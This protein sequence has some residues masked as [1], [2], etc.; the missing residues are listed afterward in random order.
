LSVVVVEKGSVV[1]AYILSGAVVDPVSL[2]RLIPDWR[3]DPDGPLKT[4]VAR[5]EFYVLGPSGGIRLPNWPM[6][7]LM[8]NHGNFIGSL[9]A[10]TRWLG[11]RGGARR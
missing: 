1:G 10:V 7:R 3:E 9:G 8:D 5:D 6:P 11:A 4:A 2:D